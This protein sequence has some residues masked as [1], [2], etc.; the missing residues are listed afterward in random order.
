MNQQVESTSRN[1]WELLQN[2]R[3]AVAQ[4]PEFA[5]LQGVWFRGYNPNSLNTPK[6]PDAIV[7]WTKPLYAA[8]LS[9]IIA[10]YKKG[11]LAA[12]IQLIALHGSDLDSVMVVV[13]GNPSGDYKPGFYPEP[14]YASTKSLPGYIIR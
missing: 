9:G 11:L 12:W 4:L 10:K 1:V 5:Q 6:E 8:D 2:F 7:M 3:S 14:V 13:E